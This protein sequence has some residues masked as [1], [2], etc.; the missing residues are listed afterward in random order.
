MDDATLWW[1]VQPVFSTGRVQQGCP[2]QQKPIRK[3]RGGYGSVLLIYLDL[4]GY[5]LPAIVSIP[6]VF[7]CYPLLFLTDENSE[8]GDDP[9]GHRNR[10][11]S[12]LR[13]GYFR[14]WRKYH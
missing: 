5:E 13:T 2:A 6:C 4:Q 10:K 8:T 12:L 3:I 14:R 9:D 1:L 7:M 11:A